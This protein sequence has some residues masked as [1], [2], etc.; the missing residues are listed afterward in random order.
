MLVAKE[1][2]ATLIKNQNNRIIFI[3]T[4]HFTIQA[5]VF[6]T[7]DISIASTAARQP[8]GRRASLSQAASL[9]LSF[10]SKL[11]VFFIFRYFF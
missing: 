10:L 4:P 7:P 9:Q 11:L 2:G 8:D 3:D 1:T 6:V 5:K